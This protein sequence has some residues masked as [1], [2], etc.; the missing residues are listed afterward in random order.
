MI[1]NVPAQ[2]IAADNGRRSW[3]GT[4][5]MQTQTTHTMPSPGDVVKVLLVSAHQ[6]DRVTL[7]RILSRTKWKLLVSS[8][9]QEALVF[10]Q[11]HR[12]PVVIC[13]SESSVNNW[14]L[15][16]HSFADLPDPPILIVSSRLADEC[17]WAEVLN[18]GGYDV[19]PT[20]FDAGEVLRVSFLAWQFW[21]REVGPRF[22]ALSGERSTCSGLSASRG[23][24]AEQLGQKGDRLEKAAS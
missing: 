20:P 15:L 19:L 17:L 14:R 13:D 22:S 23:P 3:K 21:E 9:C 12:V 10:L 7:Q 8:N 24:A 1:E 16:L 11:Q 2:C 4:K 18:L 5:T 6:S